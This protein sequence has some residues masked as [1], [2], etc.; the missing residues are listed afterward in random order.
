MDLLGPAEMATGSEPLRVDQ[1]DL[2]KRFAD[3]LEPG[4]LVAELLT[5]L[6]P[7]ALDAAVAAAGIFF[8][9]CR[10]SNIHPLQFIGAVHEMASNAAAHAA[11]QGT[12][13]AEA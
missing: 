13:P 2:H 11:N 9:M 10:L 1:A 7:D 12:S 4:A 8:C 3:T 6:C 5:R